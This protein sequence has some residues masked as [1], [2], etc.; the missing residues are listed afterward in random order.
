MRPYRV[1]KMWNG[2]GWTYYKR[3]ENFTRRER[4]AWFKEREE[5]LPELEGNYKFVEPAPKQVVAT[6][7]PQFQ[8]K[9]PSRHGQDT[10]GIFRSRTGD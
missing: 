3:W 8:A 9:E 7:V 5:I 2:T 6:R 1:K 10:R 4:E